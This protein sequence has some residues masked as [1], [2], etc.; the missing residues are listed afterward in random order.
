MICEVC[1]PLRYRIVEFSL[2]FKSVNAHEETMK[3][4]SFDISLKLKT[5]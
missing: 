2:A 1:P 4:P 5:G 3:Y